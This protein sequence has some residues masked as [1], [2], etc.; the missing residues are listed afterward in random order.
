MRFILGFVF[1]SITLAITACSSGPSEDEFAPKIGDIY[2]D[3]AHFH[4]TFYSKWPS[5]DQRT[6]AFTVSATVSD[7]DGLINMKEIYVLD[8]NSQWK[9]YL[10]S[11]ADANP[12]SRCYKGNNIFECRFYSTDREDY[13]GLKGY[14]LV[15]VDLHGYATSKS[16]ELKLPA[17]ELAVDETF[18][19]SDEFWNGPNNS[20]DGVGIAGLEV[21]TIA[22]NDMVFTSDLAD[23]DKIIHVEFESK[24]DRNLVQNY[25]FA[26]Y[27]NSDEP[28]LV[29]EVRFNSLSIK[30]KPIVL[31]EKT[32][33]DIPLTE[34]EFADG[35]TANDIDG[36]HVV[37]LDAPTT[38]TQGDV[39]GKWFNYLGYSEFITL[40]P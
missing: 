6:I 3:I 40:T 11:S 25:A 20:I 28:K 14:E 15:A 18:V 8:L 1:F 34:I 35:F 4:P 39:A 26:L 30:N 24:D 16:F 12:S 13:V 33:V 37:L 17:G 31:G 5:Q 32:I 29:G 19:Y 36:L 10:Y 2:T 22:N 23:K 21:M 7:P 9:W 27:D 38:W